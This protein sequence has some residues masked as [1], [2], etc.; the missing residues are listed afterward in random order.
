MKHGKRPTMAQRK[1]MTKWKLDWNDW[2]V[3]KVFLHGHT[4]KEVECGG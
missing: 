4:E 3:M 2:P 1:L